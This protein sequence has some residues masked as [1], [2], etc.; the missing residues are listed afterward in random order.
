MEMNTR[1]F[2]FSHGRKPKTFKTKLIPGIAFIASPGVM[3]IVAITAMIL[4]SN[5]NAICKKPCGKLIM[6]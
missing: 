1:E 4:A 5:W 2:E 3:A 6:G